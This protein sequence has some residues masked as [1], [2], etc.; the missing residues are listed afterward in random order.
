MQPQIQK[1][2]Q[3]RLVTATAS[4]ALREDRSPARSGRNGLFF[5][6]TRHFCAT[7]PAILRPAKPRHGQPSP[8][9][10]TTKSI[11]SP[12]KPRGS[13]QYPSWARRS[14]ASLRHHP[15]PSPWAITSGRHS[16][17]SPPAITP[18]QTGRPNRQARS[19]E[20]AKSR[21]TPWIP[22]KITFFPAKTPKTAGITAARSTQRAPRP[23]LR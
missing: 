1:S 16:R 7:Y 10:Q 14:A 4:A 22:P 23:R 6:I 9:L 3:A 20:G 18:G 15:G 19:A 21:S 5:A 12:K 13:P 17:P 2:P 11:Q 8:V